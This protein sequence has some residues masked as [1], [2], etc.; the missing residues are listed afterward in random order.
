MSNH[1]HV[2]V[3][4]SNGFLGRN[5]TSA[6]SQKGISFSCVN[7][8]NPLTS[9]DFSQFSITHVVHLAGTNRPTDPSSFQSD[10]V[11]LTSE[12]IEALLSLPNSSSNYPH[13]LFCSSIHAGNSTQY[14]QTKLEAESS[15][16]K[17]ATLTNTKSYSLRLPG[18]FGKWSKPN[19]NSVVA[20]FCHNLANDIPLSILN[21]DS[22]ISLLY[23][24]DLITCILDWILNPSPRIPSPAPIYNLTVHQ[25]AE[26][27]RDIHSRSFQ[28]S[29]SPTGSG[30]LRALSATY[31]SF[32]PKSHFRFPISCNYDH[33]GSFLEFIQTP[34]HGQVSVLTI[35]P[36]QTRGNHYHNTKHERFLVVSGQATFSQRCLLTADLYQTLLDSSVPQIVHTIPGH[37]HWLT[38]NHAMPCVVLIW[39][40]EI[41]DQTH[42]DTYTPQ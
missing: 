31:L 36:G 10:N 32:L 29:I 13:V 12:L 27:L 15:I 4:G 26:L 30:L 7:R 35:N 14:G 40:N 33:R 42:P 20:T 6:L 8:T 16:T 11:K 38:N 18:I 34:Q 22:E 9:Y 2:L 25:L 37:V 41:F 5:L 23:I 21:P 19:Y 17:Y 39:S 3:T 28:P 1:I 24:D